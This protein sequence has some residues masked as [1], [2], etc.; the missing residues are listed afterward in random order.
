MV[1]ILKFQNGRH[2]GFSKFGNIGF[3][4]IQTLNFIE[5]QKIATPHKNP[6]KLHSDPDYDMNIILVSK[7][8]SDI[9]QYVEIKYSV[10]ISP[11]KSL[12]HSRWVSQIGNRWTFLVTS[13]FFFRNSSRNM[14]RITD[15]KS[16][17][18]PCGRSS[19]SKM[20]SKM[21]AIFIFFHNFQTILARNT[22][23]VSKHM[24]WGMK[25][26]N[27]TTLRW[28]NPCNSFQNPR[29]RPKWPPCFV[30]ISPY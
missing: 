6:A 15:K 27:K 20:A 1:A 10:L 11:S 4:F 28:F 13:W 5:M 30:I 9:E 24:F 12:I 23:L 3:H 16:S 19:K 14:W 21:A 22:N 25:N 2:N 29:W 26:L 7:C 8:F 18:I 17:K